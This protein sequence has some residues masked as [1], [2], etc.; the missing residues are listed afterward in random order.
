M[1]HTCTV[2]DCCVKSGLHYRNFEPADWVKFGGALS[3]A[4]HEGTA[5]AKEIKN[6]FI[7]NWKKIYGNT[8]PPLTPLGNPVNLLSD[9][10]ILPSA[11]IPWYQYPENEEREEEDDSDEDTED[12][13]DGTAQGDGED[14]DDTDD[15]DEEDDAME[16]DATMVKEG[17]RV[18]DDAMDEDE[19]MVEQTTPQEEDGREEQGDPDTDTPGEV[20]GGPPTF[21]TLEALL[22]RHKPRYSFKQPFPRLENLSYNITEYIVKVAP[23]KK[24]RAVCILSDLHSVVGVEGLDPYAQ[25]S[26]INRVDY[27]EIIAVHPQCAE[28]VAELSEKT[29]RVSIQMFASTYSF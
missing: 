1:S 20:L 3:E 23:R 9:D 28:I 25:L 8:A 24:L 29:V 19:P 15:K 5:V 13:K 7:L 26:D 12:T 22:K 10:T 4:A 18:E 14:E 21:R 17:A 2:D 16:E 6:Q 27:E 11:N